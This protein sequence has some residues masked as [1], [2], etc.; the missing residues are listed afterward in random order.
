MRCPIGLAMTRE[1]GDR[2]PR[3]IPTTN[4]VDDH[5]SRPKKWRTNGVWIE[6]RI[7]LTKTPETMEPHTPPLDPLDEPENLCLKKKRKQK[8]KYQAKK[9]SQRQHGAWPRSCL[10]PLPRC[11]AVVRCGA[12]R[13][14]VAPG[15]WRF[16][17]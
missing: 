7:F 17:P 13:Y 6:I 15:S 14:G 12:M 1:V 16:G 4:N 3:M 9:G 5:L 8:F 10:G 2:S 11:G